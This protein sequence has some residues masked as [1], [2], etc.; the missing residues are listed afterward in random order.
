MAGQIDLLRLLADDQ[1]GLLVRSSSERLPFCG[2]KISP[3]ILA[4]AG[5]VTG[6]TLPGPKNPRVGPWP[7]NWPVRK[8]SL[9]EQLMHS[10]LVPMKLFVDQARLACAIGSV[11]LV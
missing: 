6:T 4:R 2:E 7:P 8:G 5:S 9:L 3:G 1:I 11:W 10:A